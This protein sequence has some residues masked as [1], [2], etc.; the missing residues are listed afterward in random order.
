ME[1]PQCKH[2]NPPNSKFCLKCGSRQ[3]N[4]CPQCQ[5]ALPIE[6]AFCNACGHD[7]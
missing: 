4:F 2:D 3:E 5:S 1:C 6:A 7:L